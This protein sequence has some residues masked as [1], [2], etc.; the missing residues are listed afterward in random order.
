M[1]DEEGKPEEKVVID[2]D[3]LDPE[4]GF[5]AVELQIWNAFEGFL[6]KP[7]DERGEPDGWIDEFSEEKKLDKRRVKYVTTVGIYAG[8]RDDFNQRV[9]SGKAIYANGDVYEGDFYEGKKHGQGHY[10]FKKIG[11]SEVDAAL[12]K[13]WKSKQESESH[14]AFV[15][16]AAEYL[17]IGK[18]IVETAL[19]YGFYPC[20]HGDYVFGQRSGEGLMK[21]KDGSV[22]KGQWLGNKRH[23]QGIMYFLNGDTY[24]GNWDM[25]AKHGFGVYSFAKGGENRGEWNRGVFTE[26]QWLMADGNYYEGRFDKKNRPSDSEASMHFPGKRISM[27]GVFKKG[28]WAPLP[29]LVV[30][31]EKPHEAEWQA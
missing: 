5:K 7:E 29:D 2:Y 20:Y 24:S 21:N 22:Y 17:Q 4:T 27:Q 11:R 25:G 9:G 15:T 8:P 30:C 6:A 1:G 13:M 18:V 28:K 16:R 31:D 12:E 23:G 26:G 19:E 14:E 3:A 10:T